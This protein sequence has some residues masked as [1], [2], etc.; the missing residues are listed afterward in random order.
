[1]PAKSASLT[2]SGT[3]KYSGII[4]DG[5]GQ[6]VGNKYIPGSLVVVKDWK[7]HYH[8]VFF[9]SVQ[10]Y[11]LISFTMYLWVR[12]TVIWM[13]ELKRG[14]DVFYNWGYFFIFW[15][16]WIAHL[17]QILIFSILG[18][19]LCIVRICWYLIRS[20]Y[21]FTFF[22]CDVLLVCCTLMFPLWEVVSFLLH[23]TFCNWWVF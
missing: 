1:M 4:F 3:G 9:Q 6:Q 22:P 2:N 15:E 21:S 23:L 18:F 14:V 7:C 11:L 13:S 8:F 17:R 19:L 16:S 12:D 10:N 5:I 20:N